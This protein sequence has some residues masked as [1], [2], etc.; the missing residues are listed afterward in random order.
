VADDSP[1]TLVI[2]MYVLFIVFTSKLHET[3]T[4]SGSLQLS[5]KNRRVIYEVDFSTIDFE[6]TQPIQKDFGTLPLFI[7]FVKPKI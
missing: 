6:L 2:D 7:I 4:K 5:S 3:E 1:F